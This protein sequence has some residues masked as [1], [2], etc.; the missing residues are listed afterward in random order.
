M[1]VALP[2]TRSSLARAR[3]PVFA[4]VIAV[5]VA[6][7]LA[8]PTGPVRSHPHVWIDAIAEMVF[9]SDRSLTGIRVYWAFD[10]DYS[11]FAVEGLDTNGNGTYEPAELAPLAT[12][13]IKN[14]KEFRYFTFVEV[15][16]QPAGYGEVETFGMRMIEGR[17]ALW[18]VVPL[19]TPVDPRTSDV[20]FALYDP[21][22]YVAVDF[23]DRDPVR[24]TG[25][26][27]AA[28]GLDVD[29][30]LDEGLAADLPE[31]FFE[32]LAMTD[33]MGMGMDASGGPDFSTGVGAQ[34]ARWARLVC[35]AGS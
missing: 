19:A 5:F 35:G 20:A 7:G 8:Y 17:L 13:N 32:T 29:E 27:P 33:G 11:A 10:E 25:A 12:E 16:D 14:L 23:V 9:D 4:G 31:S 3:I 1:A 30:P 22:Y 21:T 24:I 6:I 15:D 26:A 28:C 18:F 34:F 2:K